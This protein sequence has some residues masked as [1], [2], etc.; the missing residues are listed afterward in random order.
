MFKNKKPSEVAEICVFVILPL[1]V[2]V[3]RSI[4]AFMHVFGPSHTPGAQCF[5]DFIVC[6]E[7]GIFFFA[8]ICLAFYLIYKLWCFVSTKWTNWLNNL[9]DD[10]AKNL[11]N[12]QQ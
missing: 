8:I 1:I 12:Q 5:S 2:V 7:I 4:F 9:D 10:S 6:S 11:G 3:V